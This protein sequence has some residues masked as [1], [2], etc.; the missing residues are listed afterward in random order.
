MLLMAINT[1]KWYK[2][3]IYKG[4]LFFV[5]V[6]PPRTTRYCFSFDFALHFIQRLPPR[7]FIDIIL[8][9]SVAL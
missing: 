6:A 8:L 3:Y 1:L 2:I 5:V 7:L 9:G 4:S